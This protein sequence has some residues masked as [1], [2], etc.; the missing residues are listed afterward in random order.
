MT[1]GLLIVIAL[2]T[3]YAIYVTGV[4]HGVRVCDHVWREWLGE[5][6][7]VA[8]RTQVSD[9]YPEKKND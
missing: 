9:L 5:R 1:T 8:G 2:A 6:V 7:K 4:T 3:A